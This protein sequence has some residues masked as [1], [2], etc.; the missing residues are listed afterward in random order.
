[1]RSDLHP[2]HRSNDA[3]LYMQIYLCFIAAAVCLC[4]FYPPNKLKSSYCWKFLFDKI[5]TSKIQKRK[6]SCQSARRI[7]KGFSKNRN[8][9]K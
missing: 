4:R 2:K 7:L 8:F 1:M 6:E 5:V 9:Y 3:F